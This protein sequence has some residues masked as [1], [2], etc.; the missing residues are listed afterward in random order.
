MR[1]P[2]MERIE[3]SN[4]CSGSRL[5][6]DSGGNLA[7]EHGPFGPHQI[8]KPLHFS[9]LA[10]EALLLRQTANKHAPFGAFCFCS[11][12]NAHSFSGWLFWSK[13]QG[14][15]TAPRPTQASTGT[16][17]TPSPRWWLWR[18]F[19]VDADAG[20]GKVPRQ[21]SIGQRPQRQMQGSSPNDPEQPAPTG[22]FS[23]GGHACRRLERRQKIFILKIALWGNINLPRSPSCS[24]QT[25]GSACRP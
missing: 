22:D 3:D 2:K 23:A 20:M 24:R 15:K 21:A 18:R 1:S 8:G 6:S 5:I 13:N 7:L 4:P 9:E 12:Q 19:R 10:S 25:S 14:A 16:R 17:A 11:R